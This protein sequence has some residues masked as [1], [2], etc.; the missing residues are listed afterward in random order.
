MLLFGDFF[1]KITKKV[2]PDSIIFSEIYKSPPLPWLERRCWDSIM[3]YISCMD[4]I[5]YFLTGMEK[6]NDYLNPNY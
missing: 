5:S 6:H 4:P 2:N 1:Y 3:N